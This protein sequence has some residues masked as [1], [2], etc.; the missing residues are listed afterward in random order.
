MSGCGSLITGLHGHECPCTGVS[1]GYMGGAARGCFR[2][3]Q[4]PA[5]LPFT[6]CREIRA[7]SLQPNPRTSWPI[8]FAGPGTGSRVSGV[9]VLAGTSDKRRRVRGALRNNK[10]AAWPRPYWRNHAGGP[11]A[12]RSFNAHDIR[13]AASAHLQRARVFRPGLKAHEARQMKSCRHVH[14]LA[15]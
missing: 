5:T 14:M 1:R 10:S 9:A 6:Y 4:P 8:P 12:R 3:L 7:L 2:L 15:R 11:V 13:E